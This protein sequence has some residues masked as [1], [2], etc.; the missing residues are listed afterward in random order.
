MAA[1]GDNVK[2]VQTQ[3]P[4]LRNPRFISNFKET[5]YERDLRR[6]IGK[7][8]ASSTKNPSNMV[9][10]EDQLR[11]LYLVALYSH[12][13]RDIGQKERCIR[14]L[15][16]MVLI[17]EGIVSQAFDYDYAPQ[18][19]FVGGTRVWLNVSQEGRDDLDDLLEYG[20]I[21]AY[22]LSSSEGHVASAFQ[23]APRGLEAIK[24]LGDHG[25]GM[26]L[27]LCQ[28]PHRDTALLEVV[29]VPAKAC[30]ELRGPSGFRRESAATDSE[31]V[32][33][34]SSP[35][36]PGCLRLPYSPATTTFSHRAHE[37]SK[38]ASTL[39]D[40]LAEV[41][42]LS[43]VRVL[44]AEWIPF[45]ANHLAFLNGKLACAERVQG[46]L[47][48]ALVDTDTSG[49]QALVVPG[50]SSVR[51]L[52]YASTQHVNLEASIDDPEEC[53]V[54][55][56]ENFGVSVRST[57]EI[58][59]GLRVEAI[60]DR[61][62][63]HI[64]VDL[65]ARLLVDVTIDSNRLIQNLLSPYQQAVLDTLYGGV[66][67]QRSKMQVIMTESISPNMMARKY[68]DKE[69]NENELKQVLGDTQSAHDLANDEVLIVGSTGILVAGPRIKRHESLLVSFACL[70]GMDFFAQNF[71]S[72]L[73]LLHEQILRLKNLLTVRDTA[74]DP[75]LAR[76]IRNDVAETNSTAVRME[77]VLACLEEALE[78]SATAPIEQSDCNS[79]ALKEA[80]GVQELRCDLIWRVV[81]LKRHTQGSRTELDGVYAMLPM[82]CDAQLTGLRR[83]MKVQNG[84]LELMFEASARM[85]SAI[86][87]ML[88]ILAGTLAF[89]LLDRITGSWSISDAA[90]AKNTLDIL[91]HA[92]AA[93]FG[94]SLVA[95][96]S[97][98]WASRRA[99][100][101]HMAQNAGNALVSGLSLRIR[102][103]LDISV[104][105]LNMF[106]LAK[107]V[108]CESTE[109]LGTVGA[110]IKVARYRERHADRE[111]WLGCP[112]VVELT[113]LDDQHLLVGIRLHVDHGWNQKDGKRIRVSALRKVIFQELQDQ[114]VIITSSSGP[115][116]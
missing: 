21:R 39:R 64:S 63:E 57:G 72:R 40:E 93:W 42:H 61:V 102:C 71:F 87:V 25:K 12:A 59:L 1:T 28:D 22:R 75:A 80:L 26:V 31:D 104:R 96:Y 97:V 116:S 91:L 68:L 66:P 92:P 70:K 8:V 107:D 74:S 41:I 48:S 55:Q 38:G 17:F 18:S 98:N 84:Q 5:K 27:A 65:L 23:L 20:L 114:S 45:G 51:V 88:S 86:Y 73:F 109:I 81:D 52:D 43:D 10:S 32:S 90:W 83:M 44:M 46:G 58:C 9:W 69:D 24:H 110:V 2:W 67:L 106:L 49:T 37:A 100:A 33:Y 7:R 108:L 15:P 47:F 56:V 54:V 4:P 29:W 89:D 11:L 105:A 50:T 76:R 79:A 19:Q 30:F 77:E 13:A 6:R 78:R 62:G 85:S 60:M 82:Q 95:W 3:S 94:I 115:I 35:Y 112:P 99:V 103:S 36:V 16:L 34:V 14:G 53:G 113:Y 111:K 101:R